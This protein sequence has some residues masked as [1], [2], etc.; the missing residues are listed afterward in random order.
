[1][2]RAQA[3]ATTGEAYICPATDGGYVMLSLPGEAPSGIFD[4]VEWSTQNTCISQIQ[5]LRRSGV[6]VRVG[7]TFHDIDT[8]EDV[9]RLLT[10]A[11]EPSTS[12]WTQQQCG[13]T[14]S[15]LKELC[16]LHGDEN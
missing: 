4:D 8:P 9:R 14:L 1:M 16:S 2:I 5:A 12:V 13:R 7:P 15:I 11:H 3:T 10:M 6:S